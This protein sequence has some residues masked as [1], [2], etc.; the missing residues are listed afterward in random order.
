MTMDASTSP[1]KSL[2]K[3]DFIVQWR[4]RRALIMS[5][6][7]PVV[8]IISWKSLIPVVGAAAVLS[9]CLAIGL[10]GTGFMGYA[11]TIARDRER[12]VF[13]RLRTAPIS[14]RDIM[15]SRIIVQLAVIL[16]MTIITVAFGYEIDH[17]A[18]GVGPFFLVLIAALI[19]G[20]SFLALGQL[21]VAF[22]KTS[23]GTSAAV[24]LVYFPLAVLGA[25]GEI[26]VF[27]NIVKQITVWSPFGTMESLLQAAIQPSSMAL[28]TLWA[29][30]A[31]L[32]YGIFFAAI[33]IKWFRWSAV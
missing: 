32:A 29:L 7:L 11:L 15:V 27:G 25:I 33:G 14:S 16:I 9:I 12:G 22:T 26:G 24:R 19:G 5:I 28:H 10:P 17:I 2:L 30:I 4:Q 18:I 23:E 13:Q 3:A 6:V 21:V 1:F 20:L 31:T 8:F